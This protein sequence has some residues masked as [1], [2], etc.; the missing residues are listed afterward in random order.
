MEKRL[1]QY[2]IVC[3]H[4]TTIQVCKTLLEGQAFDHFLAAK[5][6]TVKRYGGEGAESMYAFFLQLF[7]QAPICEFVKRQMA[8]VCGNYFVKSHSIVLAGGITDIMIAIPHRGR[9][10]LLTGLLQFPPETVFRKM[11]GLPEYE[12][13]KFPTA[14]GDVLSHL[15]TSVSLQVESLNGID[16]F[17]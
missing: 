9:L 10:N 3:I 6:A 7:L 1:L 5:F 2:S 4:L 15:F 8:G 14:T 16:S 12:T 11:R 13:S 17:H